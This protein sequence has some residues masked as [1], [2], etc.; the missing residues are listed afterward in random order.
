MQPRLIAGKIITKLLFWR[1][2]IKQR[3]ELY[4]IS[5]HVLDD[6]GVNRKDA[7]REAERHFWDHLPI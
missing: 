6:I 7:L 1:E 3:N 4:K 2:L 5:N